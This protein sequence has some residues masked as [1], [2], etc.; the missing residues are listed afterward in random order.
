MTA[1][2]PSPAAPRLEADA[3]PEADPQL[4]PVIQHPARLALTAFLS[5]CLEADFRTTRD[6]LNLSDSALS[7]TVS[8][9]EAAGYVKSR[10][11]FVGRRPRTWLS[12]TEQG[13]ARLASHL[14]ALQRI[15][16]Q[17]RARARFHASAPAPPE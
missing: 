15:A 11:G 13:R 4:D 5:G 9:L 17:A 12:L 2:E 6:A 14:D 10:K 1:D 3:Q 8:A 16:T 7:K